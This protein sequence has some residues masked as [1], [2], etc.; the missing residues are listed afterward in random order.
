MTNVKKKEVSEEQYAQVLNHH[1]HE[2]YH[3]ALK[4]WQIP[5]LH[6]LIALAADHP[7]IKQTKWPTKQLIAQVRWWC[8]EKFSEWGFS[9]EEV[10][11]LDRMRQDAQGNIT[12][13]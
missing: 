6:G 2:V 8:K 11:Y 4:G 3:I 13:E 12:E 7:D 5:I 9:P 1:R 10:E